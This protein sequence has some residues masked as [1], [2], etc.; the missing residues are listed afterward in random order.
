MSDDLRLH[1]IASR[2]ATTGERGGNGYEPA[3]DEIVSS[4]EVARIIE[5]VHEQWFRTGFHGLKLCFNSKSDRYVIA[6]AS[7][8]QSSSTKQTDSRTL[9]LM[10]RR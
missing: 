7:S 6:G 1:D 2:I 5:L 4:T 9:R 10:K 3:S 8:R